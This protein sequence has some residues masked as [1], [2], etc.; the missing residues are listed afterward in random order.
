VY[1]DGKVPDAVNYLTGS[2]EKSNDTDT[3]LL[4]R[5]ENDIK[6]SLKN[7]VTKLGE[8]SP[9]YRASVLLWAVFLYMTE[10]AQSFWTFFCTERDVFIAKKWL[11]YFFTIFC[12]FIV[13]P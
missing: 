2:F 1:T 9:T 4:V 3:G 6:D 12:I 5:F 7:R 13:S 8:F 10:V 11:G